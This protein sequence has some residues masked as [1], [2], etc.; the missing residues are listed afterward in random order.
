MKKFLL[1]WT[2]LFTV[3]FASCKQKSDSES[4]EL[5]DFERAKLAQ[6]EKVGVLHN[7][8][9]DTILYDLWKDKIL[10][11]K[12]ENSEKYQISVKS[13]TKE[14]KR[15]RLIEVAYNAIE[16]GVKNTLHEINDDNIKLFAPKDKFIAKIKQPVSTRATNEDK[17]LSLLTPI[18]KQYA[19]KLTSII[20]SQYEIEEL[21][22]EI[23]ILEKEIIKKLSE[24]EAEIFSW[25]F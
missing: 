15:D 24:A 19:Q 23:V 16:R 9:L 12:E 13:S 22:N 10:V 4:L 3:G 1:F 5:T 25:I 7:Q 18:Q 21:L 11:F 8:I 20:D 14:S 17:T 2:V 6:Y